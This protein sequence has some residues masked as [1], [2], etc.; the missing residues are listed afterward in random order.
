MHV[1][2][3]ERAHANVHI[4]HGMSVQDHVILHFRHK[5]K[6]MMRG[7]DDDSNDDDDDGGGRG[8]P[9]VPA[10]QRHVR[11]RSQLDRNENKYLLNSLV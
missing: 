11:T 8:R 10:T 1:T 4:C 7:H 6:T 9:T 2:P 3:I 5:T